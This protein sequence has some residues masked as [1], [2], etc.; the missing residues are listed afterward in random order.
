[1]NRSRAV[2][3]AT[4]SGEPSRELRTPAKTPLIDIADIRRALALADFD[5]AAARQRMAPVPRGWQKRN[6]PPKRA[7]VM[8]LLFPHQDGRLHV[9]LTLRNAGLRGHSG[10]VSFPRRPARS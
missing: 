8:I 10:Q 4:R 5:A 7:A 3:G 6:S 1:M 2:G 9:V